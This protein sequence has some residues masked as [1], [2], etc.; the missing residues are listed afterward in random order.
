[1]PNTRTTHHLTLSPIFQNNMVIPA[2]KAWSVYGTSSESKQHITAQIGDVTQTEVTDD[3]GNFMITMPPLARSL[4]N[5]T[6]RI[7]IVEMTS[8]VTSIHVG[9]VFLM[10]G[11]S[12][13][14]FRLQDADTFGDTQKCLP[15]MK[16]FFYEVP[17]LEFQRA[18]GTTLPPDLPPAQWLPLD[19]QHVKT[20][21]AVA[22]YAAERYQ[23]T[24]PNE[25]IG[26]V[27]CYKGGT[28]ASAWIDRALLAENPNL[29]SRYIQPFDAA[30]RGK[31]TADFDRESAEFWHTVD[32]HDQKLKAYLA[33]HPT[34]SLSD[35]KN[36][37]GHTPWP[38]PARPESYL[39]PGGLW[40]TMFSPI[41]K[42]TFSAVIWYQGE[43][44]TDQADAYDQL[45]T[46]LITSWRT[47]M[48]DRSLPFFVIQLPGYADGQPGTWAVLR[49]KQME[50]AQSVPFVHLISISD[51]GEAHNIHPTDKRPVGYRIGRF[52]A[53][54]DYPNTPML[55]VTSWTNERIHLRIKWGYQFI[56]NDPVHFTCTT[57][58]GTAEV[59][60]VRACADSIVIPGNFQMFQY[61]YEN[62]PKLSL[63]NENGDPVS[64][65][66]I[67]RKDY[68]T[69][70]N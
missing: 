69:G 49:Q 65:V 28:S 7:N 12:N 51:T 59:V 52:L 8:V 55:T 34:T 60:S 57:A 33:A 54:V 41:A 10:A 25:W 18:D 31:S 21:S 53:G 29:S 50:V 20:M 39:R 44:D 45:L 58:R 1:M 30:I 38:F 37:V 27:D 68:D 16:G 15:K 26:I 40:E 14:E 56:T 61:G 22:F 4:D 5:L 17:Q 36:I 19:A 64:P 35:A 23:K 63:F 47:Q 6:L 70:V 66:Q 42:F 48:H 3:A 9:Q 24:H 13:I 46:L 67:R 2:H 32:V 62:F 11:Q 43:N